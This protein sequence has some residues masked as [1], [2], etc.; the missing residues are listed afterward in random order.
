M[1][2]SLAGLND[3]GEMIPFQGGTNEQVVHTMYTTLNKEG[4]QDNLKVF[5]YTAKDQNEPMSATKKARNCHGRP[6]FTH[7]PEEKDSFCPQ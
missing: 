6:L 4:K 7:S 2:L 3:L 1:K 5:W